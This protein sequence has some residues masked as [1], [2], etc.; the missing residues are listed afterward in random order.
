M[1]GNSYMGILVFRTC[2]RSTITRQKSGNKSMV[3][4]RYW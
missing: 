4:D 3:Y 2:S 1:I